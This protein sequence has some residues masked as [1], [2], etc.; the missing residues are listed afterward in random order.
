MN[1]L[2]FLLAAVVVFFSCRVRLEESSVKAVD[3][4]QSL[5]TFVGSTLKQVIEHRPSQDMKDI[6]KKSGDI[7][8]HIICPYIAEA[9]GILNTLGNMLIYFG[10]ETSYSSEGEFYKKLREASLL[11][12]QAQLDCGSDP[13]TVEVLAVVNKAQAILFSIAKKVPGL[14]L[15]PKAIG[16]LVPAEA[17]E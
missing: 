9:N 10:N 17:P 3:N 8:M 16:G 6:V 7:V 11:Y 2:V 14:E 15:D 1:K 13:K 4:E 5:H 12:H